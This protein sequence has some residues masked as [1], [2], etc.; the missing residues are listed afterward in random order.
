MTRRMP[1][2][3]RL[4][5]MLLSFALLFSLT[6][7][8]KGKSEHYQTYVESLISANYLGVYS[9]YMNCT[10]SS[11][12]DADAMYLQNVSRLADNLS[13]YYGL[14]I[15]N[16]DV[17]T[18]L[19][20]LSKSIYSKTRFE[21]SPAYK[22]NNVYYVDVTVY[23][24]DII[25]NTNDKVLAYVQ[26]FNNR[27]A[28]GE[29]NN[30]EKSDYETSFASGLI[31]IL[32]EACDS[33]TYRDPVTIKARIITSKD[34]FYISND[35]FRAIDAAVLATVDTGSPAE[36][37]TEETED[38]PSDEGGELPQDNEQP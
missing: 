12:E 34:T 24:M 17:A 3:K 31:L 13:A 7:C 36:S 37:T 8:E 10:K 26:D 25:R 18:S 32:T 20:T 29:F 9:E 19:M 2:Y 21:V 22:D 6:G 16:D 11:E 15:T 33:M 1:K 27:V 23:P 14:E 4:T 30:Y 35:D 28:A 38:V 5:I